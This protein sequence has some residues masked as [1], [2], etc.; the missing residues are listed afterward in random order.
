VILLAV[1]VV[2][3]LAAL[4]W[5]VHGVLRDRFYWELI[6]QQERMRQAFERRI[7]ASEE[8]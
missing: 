3:A 5:F 7:S 1:L 4:A 6:E 8:L 2:L